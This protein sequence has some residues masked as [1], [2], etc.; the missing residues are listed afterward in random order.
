MNTDGT[1]FSATKRTTSAY[2]KYHP[3]LQVVGSKIYYVWGE[4]DGSNPQIWTAE[5]N[6]DGTGFSATKRTTSGFYKESQLQIVGNKIYYVWEGW[7]GSKYQ[8]WTAEMNTDGTGFSAT[9]RTTSAYSK[10]Y[11]QLQV[12]ASKIYYVWREDDGSY[13]QIWTAEMNTDGTGFSATKR[14]TSAYN[15]EYPQLQVVGSKIYYVWGEDDG[16]YGQIWTAEMNT[17]GTGFSATKRTTSAYFKGYPQLQVVGSKIYYVWGEDDGSYGQI[18]TAEMNTDGT[19]FSATKRTTSAYNKVYPQLQVVGSKL[20]YI[21]QKDDG[22]NYQIWTAEVNSNIVNKGDFYGLGI[23]NNTIKGFIN[24]GVDSF[25]YNAEA[26][27]YTAG[28]TVESSIDSNWNHITMTYDKSNLKLY[29]NG[30][31]EDTSAFTEAINTNPFDL[32]IGEDFNGTIDE[33]RILSI[34]R[35]PGFSP[36]GTLTSSI[37][38]SG[39]NSN[40]NTI[41]W[42][43]TSQPPNTN[44]KFQIA[45]NNDTS[46]W[47]FVGP[48]GTPSSYY[49]TSGGPICPDHNEDR[50]LKYK[51]YLSTT[52]EEVTP[53][54]QDATINYNLIPNAPSLT[55]PE[56][57]KW[58]NDNTPF[59]S[60]TFN[61]S[62]GT[63]SSFQVIIDDDSGFGSIDYDSGEQSSSNEFWQIPATIADGTW[64][65]KVK[66]QDD[67]GNWSSYSSPW[68][69]KIDTHYPTVTISSTTHFEG[70][71][72]NNNDTSFDWT[73]F[74]PSPSSGIEGYSYVLD[75]SPFTD[76]DTS[77]NDTGTSKSFR[78]LS[79][80]TYYF[81][82]RAEDNASNWG[83][84]DHYGP[85]QIDTTQ[86]ISTISIPADGSYWNGLSTISGTASDTDGSGLSEV[87]ISIKRNSIGTDKYWDGSGW[88]DSETWLLTSGTTSWSKSTGLPTWVSGED[89]TIRSRATDNVPNIEDPGSGNTLTFDT[90]R[91]SS[92]I[93]IPANGAYLNSLPTI[94]GSASD[95]DGSGITE[96]RISIKRN[97]SDEYWNG[98]GWVGLETWSLTSGTTLW[99]KSSGL[100]FWESGEDYTIRSTATDNA[101]N[102]EIPSSGNTFTFETDKPSSTITT[103]TDGAY[104]NSL[105]TISGTASDTGGS[106]VNR[107]QISI[108]RP[109]DNKYWDGT[110]WVS[111]TN[112]LWLSTIGTTTWSYDSS[113]VDWSTD[114]NYTIRSQ[115]I[116]NATNVETPS[117][118][119]TILFDNQPPTSLSISINNGDEY[120]NSTSVVL[121]LNVEDSGSGV[122]QMAFSGNGAAWTDWELYNTSKSYT[123]SSVEGSKTVYFRVKDEAGNIAP[124]VFDSIIL[125]TM[126]PTVI[127]IILSDPS[128]TKAGT[129]TF[130]ITFSENMSTT[131]NPIVTFGKVSPYDIHNITQ[132]SYSGNTWNGTFTIDTATGDGPNT[133]S[134]SSAEDLAGNQIVLNTLYIFIIDTISPAVTYTLTGT[135]V[136]V[137]EALTITFSERMNHTSVENSIII[138]PDVS[139][140]NYSWDGNTLTITFSSDLSY[141]TEY[142][143][144]IGTGA[145]D[146]AGNALEELYSW[147]FSTK[148][149]PEE[150]FSLLWLII[151][152][153]IIVIIVLL[154]VWILMRHKSEELEEELEEAE[155]EEIPP[156]PPKKA[157]IAELLEEELEEVEEEELPP[158]PKKA[159]IEELSEEEEELPPPPPK[160]K[161]RKEPSEEEMDRVDLPEPDEEF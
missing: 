31:L 55:D 112:E 1:G 44:L 81:H 74:D 98:S 15:K 82:V 124:Y 149:K 125:D 90:D 117:V 108:K 63:Q 17:D 119:I 73:Y 126:P 60:W 76:P 35:T 78:N 43:P 32:I 95:N 38:D 151:L 34:A 152:L 53:T 87:R 139:I 19:G 121:S 134:V 24:A 130:T 72:S 131:I 101:T 120:T 86:P 27:S 37:L 25:K 115:V 11:P 141:G 80:S 22:S 58:T 155:E 29:V 104:L 158:P 51:A 10:E 56:N 46:T 138:F 33:V 57:N 45:T 137:T 30:V 52:D 14:T 118:G 7:D 28:A 132:S 75:N 114:T 66:T 123:L 156:P 129:V 142:N 140:L 6:I 161:R 54:L 99:S 42:N 36:T 68:V 160:A 92:A 70:Q 65:W 157:M 21:W 109:S 159:T 88:V 48:D 128:P 111:V 94:S 16:S 89:Y 136:E 93:T 107:V 59:F 8:I 144:I 150:G 20:Y 102:V 154:L 67:N 97:S 40:F 147:S 77:I 143:V 5:M 85:I 69:V 91:P 26:I 105:P 122:Y 50:Y 148:A 127:S 145:T 2:T 133:I 64:Y 4:S 23:S 106:K 71:W 9:K 116:D 61:D 41:S 3:Q 146:L 110:A 83:D 62:D 96:V 113:S 79:D 49:T 13:G 18:W 47:N 153:I 39:S 103:P 12:V 100:P 84:S 135:D